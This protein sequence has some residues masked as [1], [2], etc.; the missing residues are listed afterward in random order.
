MVV[1]AC[2]CFLVAHDAI[3]AKEKWERTSVREMKG[4]TRSK[5]TI[6]RKMESTAS[7]AGE[8]V[9]TKDKARWTQ[10]ES[11]MKLYPIFFS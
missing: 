11:G 5:Q 6:G 1:G 4:D 10:C 7:F 3:E 9:P 8:C 2:L